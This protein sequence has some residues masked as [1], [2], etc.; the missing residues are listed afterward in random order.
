MGGPTC[1]RCP[2]PS[3]TPI[4]RPRASAPH[5][6]AHPLRPLSAPLTPA[7]MPK[8][9]RRVKGWPLSTRGAIF[10]FGGGCDCTD[11]GSLV[12]AALDRLAAGVGGLSHGSRAEPPPHRP[13]AATETGLECSAASDVPAAAAAAGSSDPPTVPVVPTVPTAKM[14]NRRLCK[15]LDEFEAIAAAAAA[16]A[17]AAAAAGPG[18]TP[19]AGAPPPGFSAAPL[20]PSN[21]FHWRASV[22]GPPGSPYEGGASPPCPRL[23]R[24][25][26]V[27]VA[28]RL[29][30]HACLPAPAR[31]PQQ[32]PNTSPTPRLAPSTHQIVPDHARSCQILSDRARSCQIRPDRARSCQIPQLQ[33]P[34]HGKQHAH[35][36]RRLTSRAP[37]VRPR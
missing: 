6:A 37:V 32:R 34:L 11:C 33:T 2:A 3:L 12:P 17:T 1:Q 19:G 15:E 14:A 23:V 22:H 16:A 35:A 26:R 5:A 10:S 4:Q 29:P 28:H 27:R 20:Q 7:R 25:S 13:T 18:V 9:A 31:A 21:L 36:Q 24:V 30:V 8:S